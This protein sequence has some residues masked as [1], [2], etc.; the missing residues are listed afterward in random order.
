MTGGGCPHGCMRKC[1]RE[2]G[3][4]LAVLMTLRPKVLVLLSLLERLRFML[5]VAL[6]RDILGARR[7]ND[8][9]RLASREERL[10]TLALELMGA[11]AASRELTDSR[12]LA[13]EHRGL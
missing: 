1:E 7:T 10:G 12:A 6:V 11:P 9:M 5:L 13:A 3:Y 4:S 8:S 2:A